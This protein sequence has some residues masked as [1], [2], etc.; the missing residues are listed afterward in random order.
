MIESVGTSPAGA[1]PGA[2]GDAQRRGSCAELTPGQASGGLELTGG[3]PTTSLPL[4]VRLPRPL[5]R[6]SA[7]SAGLVPRFPVA[8]Q[9]P[10]GSPC[11][12]GPSALLCPCEHRRQQQRLLKCRSGAPGHHVL[13]WTSLVG[14]GPGQARPPEAREPAENEGDFSL[15]RREQGIRVA[16]PG[17]P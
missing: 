6:P 11:R 16:P 12:R 13:L 5:N 15:C 9:S 17:P 1:V 4:T 14:R 3:T 7:A 8:R 10:R 2:D